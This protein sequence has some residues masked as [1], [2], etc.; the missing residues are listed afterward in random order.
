MHTS[1]GV[2]RR[3]CPR[4]TTKTRFMIRA[5]SDRFGPAGHGIVE[6]IGGG[7]LR[8][9][10]DPVIFRPYRDFRPGATI[11][12]IGAEK[13]CRHFAL[14]GTVVWTGSDGAVGIRIDSTTSTAFHCEWIEKGSPK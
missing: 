4:R 11:I 9:I 7:G 12:M 1:I 6:D 3:A 5:H 8:L 13:W 2:E 10:P 14:S